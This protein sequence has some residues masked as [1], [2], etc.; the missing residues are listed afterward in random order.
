MCIRDS[1]EGYLAERGFVTNL[2]LFIPSYAEY[3]EQREYCAWLESV[4]AFISA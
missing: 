2:A 4:R 1:F 3:K